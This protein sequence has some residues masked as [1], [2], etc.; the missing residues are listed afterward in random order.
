MSSVT[1]T[2]SE[3]PDPD[4][5]EDGEQ[6]PQLP[7]LG[8]LLLPKLDSLQP[9]CAGAPAAAD[10]SLS[11]ELASMEAAEVFE[12]VPP[13]TR[14]ISEDQKRCQFRFH[15]DAPLLLLLLQVVVAVVSSPPLHTAL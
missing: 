15:D 8:L 5:L 10:P 6:L 1:E 7:V 14:R 9:A 4:L 13:T 11:A 3:Q 2:P 12:D